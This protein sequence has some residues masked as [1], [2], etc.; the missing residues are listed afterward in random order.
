MDDL[1]LLVDGLKREQA[2]RLVVEQGIAA[3]RH[4]LALTLNHARENQAGYLLAC[5]RSGTLIPYAPEEIERT[6]RRAREMRLPTGPPLSE[7]ETRFFSKTWFLGPPEQASE[8]DP[9]AHVWA[10]ALADL[11]AMNRGIAEALVSSRLGGIDD[12]GMAV[13]LVRDG[14]TAGN[15]R[16]R[17]VIARTLAAVARGKGIAVKGCRLQA[18]G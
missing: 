11:Q 12:D 3:S 9:W 4:L 16:L 1:M 15:E 2:A 14:H 10:P 8:Q 17:N 18:A 6:I 7:T 5:A 13:V